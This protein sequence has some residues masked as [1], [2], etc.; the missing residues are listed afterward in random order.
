MLGH[1]GTVAQEIVVL[2]L[3]FPA[4]LSKLNLYISPSPLTPV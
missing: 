1:V 2:L 4:K 3:F